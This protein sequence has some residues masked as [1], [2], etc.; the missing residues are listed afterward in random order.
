[1]PLV[2]YLPTSRCPAALSSADTLTAEQVG[3]L[4]DHFFEFVAITGS[5]SSFRSAQALERTL[6]VNSHNRL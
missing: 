5:I 2:P 4:A 3:Q 1:M 6:L